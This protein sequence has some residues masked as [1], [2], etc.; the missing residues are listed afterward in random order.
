MKVCP[1]SLKRSHLANAQST[2]TQQNAS[3]W[4]LGRGVRGGGGRGRMLTQLRFLHRKTESERL[5]SF[6]ANT[7]LSTSPPRLP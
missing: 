7:A 5:Q 4:A 2:V 1:L 3:G 6:F